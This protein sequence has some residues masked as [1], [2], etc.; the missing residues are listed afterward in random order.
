MTPITVI[1]G[2]VT[3]P[4]DAS[5]SVLDLAILRGLGVFEAMRSYRGVPFALEMHLDR[6]EHSAAAIQVPLAPRADIDA[7]CRTAGR[8]AGDS[9]V[10]LVST[11]GSPLGAPPR[12]VV[13]GEPLPDVPDTYRLRTTIAPWHPA[14]A[15]WALAG[16][17]TLSYGPNLTATKLAKEAGFDDAF[18]LSRDGVA[19]EGPTSAI[20][21]V[22]DGVLHFPSLD[23]GVLASVTRIVVEE[24]AA[25]IGVPME[26][27]V[28]HLDTVLGADEVLVLSTVKE[29]R[30]VVA[31]DAHPFRPG[32]VTA[33]LAAGFSRRVEAEV[34]RFDR[35]PGGAPPR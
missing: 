2:V 32:P 8:L 34:A 11:P 20:G 13:V 35:E 27:G 26:T 30:P 24:V 19:L 22:T 29:V 14:G 25:E 23:L 33:A 9:I 4:A 3:D 16:A 17:K 21:W 18:L 6:L 1:D 7:W 28:H 15:E 12:T 5:I 10:R 31:V